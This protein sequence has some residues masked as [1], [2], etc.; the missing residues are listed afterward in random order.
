MLGVGGGRDYLVQSVRLTD[1][2]TEAQ[3]A[4][5]WG[6]IV[7]IL[8]LIHIKSECDPAFLRGSQGQL[9]PP[10]QSRLSSTASRPLSWTTPP[11]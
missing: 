6:H 8:L 7:N 4:K 3:S 2:K 5:R 1:K 9:S 11:K 10:S